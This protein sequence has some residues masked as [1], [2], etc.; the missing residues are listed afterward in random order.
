MSFQA[1]HMKRKIIRY[2]KN[3]RV[4]H[5]LSV[6]SDHMWKKLIHSKGA[7]NLFHP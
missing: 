1:R 5:E 4:K 3:D 6:F 2:G 7:P